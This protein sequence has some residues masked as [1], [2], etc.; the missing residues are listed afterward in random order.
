VSVSAAEHRVLVL[1]AGSSTLKWTLLDG[2]DR[3]T[4]RSGDEK[5]IAPEI[6]RRGEQVRATLHKA[7]GFDVVGH[8]VVH[9][10]TRFVDAVLV[11]RDVRGAL[12][13][14]ADLDP[15]HM[16][17]AL[18]GIDAVSSEFPSVPQVPAKTS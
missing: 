16:R 12:E 8:R 5:W 11:V 7:S 18:A 3:T 17:M 2:R 14:L 15:L 9:G 1:N 6:E 4:I 10:G 13:S